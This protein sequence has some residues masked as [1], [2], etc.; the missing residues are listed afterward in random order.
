MLT[1][2]I[3]FHAWQSALLFSVMFVLHLI[4][5]AVAFISWLLFV[6]DLV[7]IGFLT[8]RAY[9]DADTLDRFEIPPFGR[10][11]SNFVD[12]E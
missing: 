10:F 1:F 2:A 7:L 3:R 8:F 6:I 4:F 11:A 12:D 9:K 5:S